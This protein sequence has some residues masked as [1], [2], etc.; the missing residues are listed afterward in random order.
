[1]ILCHTF[2]LV[3]RELQYIQH[4]IF[5]L[6]F[7]AKVCFLPP[8]THVLL[9]CTSFGNWLIGIILHFVF[10]S[11]PWLSSRPSST[12][13]CKMH[14]GSLFLDIL[15]TCPTL[16]NLLSSMYV[17]KFVSSYSLYSS[18]LYYILH[19]PLTFTGPYLT[20]PQ[21]KWSEKWLVKNNSADMTDMF[22]F[23]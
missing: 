15:T 5:S 3:S 22:C 11:I 19:M 14:S 12:E 16:F 21:S 8:E 10:S 7:M 18:P 17:T 20:P 1:M 2:S 6:F 23:K 4:L 13:T 9:L